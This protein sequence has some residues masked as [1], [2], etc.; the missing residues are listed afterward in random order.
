MAAG[1]LP[2]RLTAY[3]RA[4]D[5][6]AALAAG[7]QRHIRKPVVVSELIG[8]VAALAAAGATARGD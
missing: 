4:E 6:D 7:Y 5:A 8:A 3:V 1:R 2:S